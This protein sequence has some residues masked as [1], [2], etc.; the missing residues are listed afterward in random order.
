MVEKQTRPVNDIGIAKRHKIAQ[1][2]R[3]AIVSG[4]Y[5]PGQQLPTRVVLE[6]RFKVSPETLQRSF[7]EL[8]EDGF[9]RAQRRGGTFVVDYPPH[10]HHYALA[11]GS[12]SQDPGFTRFF[13]VLVEQA[14]VFKSEIPAQ[15]PVYLGVAER[16]ENPGIQKLTH[17]LNHYRVAGVIYCGYVP[18]RF[19]Q[20]S[21]PQVLISSHTD[22]QPMQFPLLAMSN[23]HY[24]QKAVQ[25][26]AEQGCKRL[27]VLS[28]TGWEKSHQPHLIK[29]CRQ[30]GIAFEDQWF[31]MVSLR[32]P[33]NARRVTH[34]LMHA[35]HKRRPDALLVADDNIIEHVKSGLADAEVDS[36]KDV[37]IVAHA[38]FPSP[39]A[40]GLTM[41]RLGY[42]AREV[43]RNGIQLINEMKQ[44]DFQP[45]VLPIEP[46]FE[47]ELR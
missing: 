22:I 38:N 21:L 5:Q 7:D 29:A 36:S 1:S 24:A 23:E 45:Y 43:I 18:D 35:D 20:E 8:K 30:A 2:L 41:R 26:F 40:Q 13:D 42:D 39:I 14:Q 12:D 47:D 44:E 25:Y 46:Y 4:K 10:L 27:G 16:H 15:V 31:Q 28:V 9:L 34:L 33:Q 3:K 37:T 32:E 19:L 6:K 11:L 17:D